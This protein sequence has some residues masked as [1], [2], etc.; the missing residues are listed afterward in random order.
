MIQ[1]D[2][3]EGYLGEMDIGNRLSLILKGNRMIFFP[4]D[5]EIVRS[6]L[7]A[8]M[9]EGEG[10]KPLHS[11]VVETGMKFLGTPYQTETLETEG[12]EELV[13]NL[14]AFDCVTFVENVVVLAGL[15]WTGKS[16][17]LDY[18]AALERIRYRHGRLNGYPSRL[19]YFTDW[20][21][22]NGR[23]GI[24]CDVT[25][26]LG[27]SPFSKPLHAVTD[28]RDQ[29]PLLKDK[30]TFRRMRIIEATCS[31]RTR[32][33]IPKNDF[34]R[35]EKRIGDGDII[36]ITTG[37]SGLDVI[38]AGIAVHAQG[39]LRLLHASRKEGKIVLSDVS[40]DRYLQSNRDMTGIV[41]GRTVD[42]K[43]NG[44]KVG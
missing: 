33:Y 43:A 34:K 36:A 19:H 4:R 31:R 21:W 30:E 14:H 16:T 25:R 11:L 37:K 27:G 1:G 3:D 22:D 44:R 29:H 23:K 39:R 8:S 12:K 7:T 32:Y 20:L 35:V 26:E 38:H 6:L 2:Y 10:V 24:L 15:I 40:L 5:R 18:A 13:I 17:F 9:K 28:Q 41:I 42:K